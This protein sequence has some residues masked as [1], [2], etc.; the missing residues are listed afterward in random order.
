MMRNLCTNDSC[1]LM[2][3]GLSGMNPHMKTSFNQM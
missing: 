1:V 3:C 2:E